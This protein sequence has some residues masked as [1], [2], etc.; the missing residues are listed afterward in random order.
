MKLSNKAK[1]LL[2]C[3]E[4]DQT[5]MSGPPFAITPSMVAKYYYPHYQLDLLARVT[6][7]GGLKGLKEADESVWLLSPTTELLMR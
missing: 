2:I 3:F 4:Y 1:Q 5:A 6:V 7:E